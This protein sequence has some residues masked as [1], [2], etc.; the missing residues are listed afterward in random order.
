MNTI[1]PLI[2]KDISFRNEYFFLSN[3]FPCNIIYE[4][5]LFKSS[6]H[7]YQYLKVQDTKNGEWW[8]ETIRTAIEPKI[9][10]SLA[11]NDKMPKKFDE[12][13][14]Y[15]FKNLKEMKLSFMRI[16]LYEKFYN[17]KEKNELQELLINTKNFELIE[18]NTW[19]DVFWGV[20]S[21]TNKGQ[22][23]LGKLLMEIREQL[24]L[25]QNIKND[26]N[27]VLKVIDEHFMEIF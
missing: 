24:L 7:L 18:R 27:N 21:K 17:S 26:T 15:G 6:E 19:K 13:E 2:T 23:N 8:K 1:N 3:L 16:A 25:K 9:A 5:K 11:Q 12:L 22:N 4:N 20:Y 14:K 10:K